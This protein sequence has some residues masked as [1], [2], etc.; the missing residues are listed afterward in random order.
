MPRRQE[1]S[2]RNE[3][4]GV[5][6]LVSSLVNGWQTLFRGSESARAALAE[7]EADRDDTITYLSTLRLVVEVVGQS[8]SFDQACQDISQTLVEELGAETCAIAIR[9]RPQEPF[10]LQGFSSQSQ[11]AGEQELR[12]SVPESTWLGAATL[13]AAAGEATA[14][15]RGP[16]GSLT[17]TPDMGLDPGLLG[18]PFHVGGERN[19]V[20]VLEYV[21]APAQHFIRGHALR[22]VADIIGSALTIAR[23]RDSMASVLAHLESVA[24]ATRDALSEQ[25]QSLREQ[26]DRVKQLTQ[27]LIDSNQAKREFLGT[28]SHE[29]RTPL[30]AILGYTELLHDGLV[31]PVT[32]EQ[33]NMLSRVMVSTRH[34]NQ[35]IDDMLFFVQLEGPRTSVRWETFGLNELVHDVASAIPERHRSRAALRVEIAPEVANLRSDRVLL[36]RVLFHLLANGFKFTQAGEVSVTVTRA[37]SSDGVVITVRDTGVGI[38]DDRLQDIFVVF[39][40]LDMSNTRRFSGLGL[41]LALVQRCV[42]ILGGEIGVESSA[43]QGTAFTVQLPEALPP[44][45]TSELAVQ[46]SE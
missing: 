3:S 9:D 24:G 16:D 26:E 21:A 7:V 23:S 31:G 14:Y 12:M 27:A 4:A 6:S 39:R 45:E 40:Q 1:R 34:L 42:R 13:M 29:L 32:D 19:G 11:L 37:H 5:G 35:L 25:E 33:V 28:V 15:Q 18:L 44:Q 10:R 46:P 22:L 38:S 30:N 8:R 41:G 20:I 43:G 36:K 17:A 2:S